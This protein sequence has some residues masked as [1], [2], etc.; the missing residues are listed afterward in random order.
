MIRASE[1]LALPRACKRH[2]GSIL[3]EWAVSSG[4]KMALLRTSSA[5]TSVWCADG[6][7]SISD[8]YENWPTCG[9]AAQSPDVHA[10]RKSCQVE[11]STTT[12][13]TCRSTGTRLRSPCVEEIPTEIQSW[14]MGT[15]ASFESS[16]EEQSFVA[17][18]VG[19]TIHAVRASYDHLRTHEHSTTATFGTKIT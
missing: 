17:F 4:I 11:A 6:C 14:I 2:L 9:R 12:P 18:T 19:H 5:W 10:E 13:V 16:D 15:G 8:G 7:R 1:G 3:W